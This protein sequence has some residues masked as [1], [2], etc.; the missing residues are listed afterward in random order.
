MFNLSS[1]VFLPIFRAGMSQN[2]STFASLN[3]AEFHVVKTYKSHFEN[4]YKWRHLLSPNQFVIYRA[5]HRRQLHGWRSKKIKI[6]ECVRIRADHFQIWNN[7]CYYSEKAIMSPGKKCRRP[8][9]FAAPIKSAPKA[10]KI[11]RSRC[12]IRSI[13]PQHNIR[14]QNSSK[15]FQSITI[16]GRPLLLPRGG[17]H[18]AAAAYSVLFS[19]LRILASSWRGLVLCTFMF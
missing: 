12:R 18:A 4:G 9:A 2:V 7:H 19:G 17:G 6:G 1:I 15:A 8:L 11:S 14:A 16:K 3:M 5:A 10:A 13:A